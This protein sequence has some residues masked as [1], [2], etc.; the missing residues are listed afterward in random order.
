M[1]TDTVPIHCAPP[2]W[3]LHGRGLVALYRQ[4]ATWGA[5]MLLRYTDSPVGPYDELLWATA[6]HS[7]PAGPRPQVRQ[8]VVS[9]EASVRWGRRNWGIPKGLARFEWQEEGQT[10]QVR[11]SAPDGQLLAHLAYQTRGSSLPVS[12]TP[13]PA[14]F[15]TLAQPALDGETGWLLTPVSAVGKV[16]PARLTVLDAAGFH[17][18]LTQLRPRL[19]LAVP[20]LRLTFP[21]PDKV[22]DVAL[23]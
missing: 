2:P 8:I 6:P 9:S 4:P 18:P 7:S 3:T 22:G 17:A 15:R 16:Q 23:E 12:T 14:Q 1:P 10:T 11:I 13:V 20:Q 5:L 21:V 19:T